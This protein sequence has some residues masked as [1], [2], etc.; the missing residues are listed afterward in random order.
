MKYTKIY[1][2]E[3]RLRALREDFEDLRNLYAKEYDKWQRAYKQSLYQ[4][5]AL[6]KLSNDVVKEDIDEFKLQMDDDFNVQNVLTLINSIVKDINTL[7]RSKDYDKLALKVNTF[8][9]I[10]DVLGINLFVELLDDESLNDYKNWNEARINK[11][12]E[13]ADMYRQKLIEKGLI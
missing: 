8:K 6:D 11:D 3:E 7:L 2:L 13:K 4:L 9:T 12:F 10:L 5:Q 1:R